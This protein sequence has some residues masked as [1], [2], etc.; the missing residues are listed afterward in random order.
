[1]IRL[2][3]IEFIHAFTNS[4]KREQVIETF[5]GGCCYWFA[6]ILQHRFGGFIVYD[7][8]KGHFACR[9]GDEVYDVTGNITDKAE[10]VNWDLYDAASIRKA[11]VDACIMLQPYTDDDA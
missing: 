11:V 5:T 8:I 7:D 4:G 2:D 10:Y 3:V 9:I 6:V 1:M